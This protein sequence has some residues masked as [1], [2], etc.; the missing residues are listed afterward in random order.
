MKKIFPILILMGMALHLNAQDYRKLDAFDEVIISGNVEV[1][2][3]QGDEYSATVYTEG[4]E[5]SPDDVTVYSKGNTL[6]IKLYETFIDDEGPVRIAV[7]YQSIRELRCSAGAIVAHKGL[8]SADTLKIRAGSGSEL[9]L[10]VQA[11]F[12]EATAAEGAQIEI[13][14]QAEGQ[15]VVASTGGQYRALE[16]ECQ[17]TEVAASTGGEAEVVARQLLDANA[18]MGGSIDYKGAPERKNTRSFISG[19]ISRI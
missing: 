3:I 14:G 1:V 11:R 6:K 19:G 12:I 5:I 10:E 2:L 4:A 13:S 8:L 7:T 18:N 15:K 9:H 16:L 17:E